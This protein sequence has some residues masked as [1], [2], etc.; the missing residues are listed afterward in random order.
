M[1]AL[2]GG[3]ISEESF[4]ISIAILAALYAALQ[5]DSLDDP[6]SSGTGSAVSEDWGRTDGA[7][8]LDGAASAPRSFFRGRN[9]ANSCLMYSAIDGLGVRG[10]LF[11][12]VVDDE[13]IFPSLRMMDARTRPCGCPL[14]ALG[15]WIF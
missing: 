5:A 3:S 8:A 2:S 11:V 1:T 13:N 10:G 6:G 4:A 14:R 9:V 12:G 7:I 15:G